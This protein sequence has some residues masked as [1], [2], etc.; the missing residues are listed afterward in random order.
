LAFINKSGKIPSLGHKNKEYMKVKI[1]KGKK[2]YNNDVF[3]E[4][5]IM[6]NPDLSL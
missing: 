5:L 4:F 2:I 1:E 6:R 3:N